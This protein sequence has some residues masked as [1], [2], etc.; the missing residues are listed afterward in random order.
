MICRGRTPFDPEIEG[1][2]ATIVAGQTV[3]RNGKSTGNY[4]GRL[5]RGPKSRWRK[6]SGLVD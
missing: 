3:Y 2:E 5:I 6:N 4:P 1:I